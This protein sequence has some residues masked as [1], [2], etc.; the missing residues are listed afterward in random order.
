M[1]LFLE[2]YGEQS[3]EETERGVPQQLLRVEVSSEDK[4]RELAERLKPLFS[5]PK[6]YLHYCYH[7]EDPTKPCELVPLE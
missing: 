1:K 6:C 4:A 3:P 7:D 2:I 5:N